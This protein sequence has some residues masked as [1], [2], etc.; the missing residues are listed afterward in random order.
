MIMNHLRRFSVN[1]KSIRRHCS[2]SFLLF[3]LLSQCVNTSYANDSAASLA[4]GGIQLEKNDSVEI[5]SEILRLSP[6]KVVVDYEFRNSSDQTLETLVAFP[7]PLLPVSEIVDLPVDADFDRPE[8]FIEFRTSVNGEELHPE[9]EV[10]AFRL[11]STGEKLEEVSELVQQAGLLLSPPNRMFFDVVAELPKDKLQPLL[12]A[13][14]LEVTHSKNETI[15]LPRWALQYTFFSK[16]TFPAHA[17]VHVHHEYKPIAGRTLYGESNFQDGLEKWCV[18]EATQKLLHER[19]AQQKV[20]PGVEKMLE[21]RHVDYVLRTASN[22]KSPIGTF[23]L[24][25]EKSHPSQVISLCGEAGVKV[26]SKEFRL[27]KSNFRPSADLT[28]AFFDPDLR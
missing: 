3:V 27:K 14:L 12:D 10:K 1:G 23:E 15:Y 4:A 21:R 8:G 26:S 5:L 17:I 9:R 2:A 18:D 25:L 28:V 24:I 22:W 6:K 16:R 13:K 11:S 20:S 19:I 7:L